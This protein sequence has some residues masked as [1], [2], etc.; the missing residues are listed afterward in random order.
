V[1]DLLSE[2]AINPK[3]S[4]SEPTLGPL[5]F[6]V[7]VANDLRALNR[8]A[9][10][11]GRPLFQNSWLRVYR[12]LEGS[13][14]V[15]LA[16]P[17]LGAPQAVLVL[18]K[19]GA[20]GVKRVLFIGWAGSLTPA[21][22]PGDLLLPDRAVSEEGTSRHYVPVPD[23]RPAAA[24]VREIRRSLKKDGLPFRT[25]PVWT[26]DAPYR[27]TWEKIRGHQQE[28][29]AAVEMETAAL[30]TV[31]A[32]RKIEVAALLVISD[33]LSGT[34]WRHAFRDPRFL[35]TRIRLREWLLTHALHL[36][37]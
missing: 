6:L 25:A 35:Q 20:L 34:R 12:F 8:Q 5:A 13:E 32:F 4:R 31:G 10:Q 3:K 18:E 28:G 9:G 36:P 33:E 14:Q 22:Q 15:A 27:E 17:V 21:L 23:P 1:T 19:L 11:Q 26:T 16:G 24:W 30:F 2:C 7:A 37:A 29:V